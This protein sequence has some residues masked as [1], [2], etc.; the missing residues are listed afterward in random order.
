MFTVWRQ[1]FTIRLGV[2]RSQ[3]VQCSQFG[4]ER[5]Q[6]GVEAGVVI[7]VL[8]ARVLVLDEEGRLAILAAL[9][10]LHGLHRLGLIIRRLG[11]REGH[12]MVKPYQ[13]FSKARSRK[14][15]KKKRPT[16]VASLM[17]VACL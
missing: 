1:T 17:L 7:G 2:E 10:V 3:C 5:S 16:V 11:Q 9:A 4:V 8:A 13:R 14:K 15:K 6:L 12:K